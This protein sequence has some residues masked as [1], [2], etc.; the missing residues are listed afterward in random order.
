MDALED[1]LWYRV[2]ELR[3]RLLSQ[4]R[5]Q[6]RVRREHVWYMLCDDARRRYHRLDPPAW[7][8][9]GRLNGTDTVDDIWQ[10]VH[11]RLGEDAPS[12]AEVLQILAQLASAELLLHHSQLDPT[13]VVSSRR[14]RE[15]RRRAAAVNPLMFK[16]PLFDPTRLLQALMPLAR[17]L[18]TPWTAIA[19][20]LL[21]ALAGTIADNRW[22]ELSHALKTHGRSATFLLYIWLSY[23]FVKTL[24]EAC[25][26]MAVKVW[27]GDVREVGVSL[28]LLSPLPYVD[29]SAATGFLSRQRRMIV[30]AVGV[31]AELAIAALALLV[32]SL[33]NSPAVQLV[34]L[35]VA[36][37][38][39]VSTLLFNANPLARFDGYHVLCDALD[40]PNLAQRANAVL[41]H[42]GRSLLG[43][44]NDALPAL[45]GREA[46][47][48][49]LYGMLAGLYRIFV[50]VGVTWWLSPSY[51]VLAAI[52]A[53]LGFVGLAGPA[54]RNLA[55][56]LIFDH[57]LHGRRT[58]AYALSIGVPALALLMLFVVPAPSF[59][60]EQ[61]VVW[62]PPEAIVRVDTDG[63]LSQLMVRDRERVAP[64]QLI[65]QLDNL[66]LRGER[67]TAASR[68]QGLEVQ[69]YETLIAKPAEAARVAF[70][71]DSARA[72]LARLDDR[73]AS[74]AL[75]AHIGGVLLL[76]RD[77]GQEG[78]FYRQGKELAY[79]LPDQ[80]G[81]LVKVALSE[82][83]AAL[84]RERTTG[85]SVMLPDGSRRI[86]PARLDRE[87]PGVTRTLPSA[88]LAK[89]NGGPVPV[90][91]SDTEGR[92]AMAPVTLVDV[93]VPDEATQWIG[94]RTWVRFDHGHEPLG[95]QWARKLEQAFLSALALSPKT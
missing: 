53:G 24:H 57:R 5:V 51:P 42:L 66:A 37:G 54:L 84:V 56:F 59:T 73:I 65:A 77:G 92:Q 27:G 64:D 29:A 89:A 81:L 70:E 91:P 88:A 86:V 62:T 34:A 32:W 52:V 90:D 49:G 43:A 87:T 12:Q 58:Q 31:M 41:A 85:V 83:E 76:P 6:R 7:E 46:A 45:S 30:G 21:L 8:F 61:G 16:V 74:L 80:M 35:A 69:Y 67:E 26:G 82:S 68:W 75:R 28:M 18:F 44:P 25:H 2:S 33:T 39:G 17:V 63:E 19:W 1:S 22:D 40:M 13:D 50:L 60:V 71:R 11:Q 55:H 72:T 94:A 10:T 36:T 79:V 23:P 47:V 93:R 95:R 78:H 9:V 20:M 3:P 38:C 48:L 4:V 14:K 15:R